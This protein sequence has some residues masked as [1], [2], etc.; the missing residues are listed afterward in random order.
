MKCSG[1]NITLLF[2]LLAQTFCGQNNYRFENYTEREG[3]PN[4]SVSSC[5]EDSK[6]YMWFGTQGGITCYDG[7][8]FKTKWN[9]KK[10]KGTIIYK[11]VEGYDLMWFQTGE[12]YNN[13]FSFKIEFLNR[14]TDSIGELRIPAYLRSNNNHKFT[15]VI[16]DIR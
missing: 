5:L 12:I 2:I 14:I 3:L 15:N 4:Q 6:G 16:A 11:I 9:D 1:L 7:Y 8:D 13:K 10:L